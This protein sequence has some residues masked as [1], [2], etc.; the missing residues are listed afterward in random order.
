M[1][2]SIFTPS[3]CPLTDILTSLSHLGPSLVEYKMTYFHD[4]IDDTLAN[5]VVKPLTTRN[6]LLLKAV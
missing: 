5:I 1:T 6:F 4:S 2:Y 3:N